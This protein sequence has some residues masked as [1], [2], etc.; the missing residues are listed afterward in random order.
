MVGAVEALDT[1]VVS[2]VEGLDATVVVAVEALDTTEAEVVGALET[3][4]VRAPIHATRNTIL[5]NSIS[6]RKK[7]ANIPSNIAGVFTKL[8]TYIMAHQIWNAH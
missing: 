1:T 2:V 8:Y 4:A 3:T 6:I 5:E 7:E